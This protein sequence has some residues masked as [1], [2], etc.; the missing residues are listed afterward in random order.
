MMVNQLW[1]AILKPKTTGKYSEK[2]KKQ[3]S[4]NQKNTKT[5]IQENLPVTNVAITSVRLQPKTL[6]LRS[7]NVMLL[8]NSIV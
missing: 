7:L 6:F 1:M 2:R 3:P 4:E 5:E 8:G